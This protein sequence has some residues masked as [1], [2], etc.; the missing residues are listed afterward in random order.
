MIAPEV[1]DIVLP[2]LPDQNNILI[3]KNYLDALERAPNVLIPLSAHLLRSLL[4]SVFTSYG[5]P[6][7]HV[8]YILSRQGMGKTTA[9]KNF[10]LPFSLTDVG[11]KAAFFVRALG[12]KAAV[13]DALTE[14]RDVAVLLDD[15]CT[16][17]DSQT[18]REVKS[19]A[20]Y[21]IRFGADNTP[22]ERK[23]GN[24]NIQCRCQCGVLITGEFP[25]NTP[26]DITRCV[27]VQITEQMT[28]GKTDD[29][30]TIAAAIS[31]FLQHCAIN[32]DNIVAE[33]K[34][35]FTK[36]DSNA[37]EDSGPR[38]Q[39]IL[40]ELAFSFRLFLRFAEQA[41][42]LTE[43]EKAEWKMK[44]QSALSNS[45][46]VNNQLLQ[47]FNTKNVTNIAELIV[48]G[49]KFGG[50]KLADNLDKFDDYPK[51]YDGFEKKGFRSIKLES[52]ARYLTD[53]TGRHWTKNQVGQKLRECGLVD[54]GKE[55][56]T[57][58]CKIGRAHV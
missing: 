10:C 26:S 13:R 25:M 20:G 7:H 37:V 38:Q 31:R 5:Y 47:D 43:A 54:P 18:Q 21:V 15:I 42:A 50:L 19:L 48:A 53:L 45:L 16:S 23:V 29:R 46:R 36:F 9:A 3:I 52:I 1:A 57:A 6:I 40:A 24:K 56:H 30:L 41:G 27:M 14:P 17:S 49:I 4:S 55:G 32:Y 33:I 11:N 58:S 22:V 39:Q 12:S 28:D 34:E 8:L 2:D 44:L 35:S 51:Q